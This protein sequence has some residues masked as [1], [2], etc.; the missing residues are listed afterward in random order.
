[1]KFLICEQKRSA[2]Y[3]AAPE[4]GTRKR[5]QAKREH[6][7][8]KQNSRAT[9]QGTVL[10]WALGEKEAKKLKTLNAKQNEYLPPGVTYCPLP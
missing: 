5:G 7:R 9:Q 1:L 4:Y 3:V 8:V 6:S 10:N 2:K